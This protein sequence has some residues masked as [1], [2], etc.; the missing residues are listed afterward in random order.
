MLSKTDDFFLQLKNRI[1][2]EIKISNE[3]EIFSK[4]INNKN[5]SESMK[6]GFQKLKKELEKNSKEIV[7]ILETVKVSNKLEKLTSLKTDSV[8]KPEIQKKE[9]LSRFSSTKGLNLSDFERGTISRLKKRDKEEKII[10]ERIKKPNSYVKT[11]NSFFSDFSKSLIKK[12]YF[13]NVQ[14]DLQKANMNF[15][16]GSYISIIVF[17]TMI[18][19]I[20]SFFIVIFLLFFNVSPQLPII[21]FAQ[22]DI[23]TRFLN[24][25]WIIFV[26]PLG[27]FLFMYTYP[28]L[29]RGSLEKKID[30]ELPFATINMSAISGSMIDPTKIFAII[31]STKDYPTLE[32]E[33]T[34]LL[35]SINVLGQDFI[36]ALRNSA[37]NTSSKQLSELYGGLATTINSG[38]DLPRFFQERA[39]T[40]LFNYNLEREK[41]T[42]AAETMMDIY[43]SVV[44]AAPMVLML[45]L[46]MMRI[47]GLGIPL[48]TGMITLVM[49]LGVSMINVGFLVFLQIKQRNQ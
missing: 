41:Q 28:S 1:S 21:T 16:L 32:K 42:K 14:T 19:F 11:A 43:I 15:L 31:V 49:I 35:N 29:E 2:K 12:N 7:Q 45:L 13:K 17:T 10:Q 36:T 39:E 40:M 6:D 24:L 8:K 27:A 25:F 37:S 26:V 22:G 23:L 18:S 44:I 5:N 4:E 3:M 38:G 34:K 46:M 47:S 20:A 33:F 30:L 9:L 48:S